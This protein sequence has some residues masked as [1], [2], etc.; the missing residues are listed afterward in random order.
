MC[1]TLRPVTGWELAHCGA[2]PWENA[3]GR[4]QHPWG[5]GQGCS[6]PKFPASSTVSGTQYMM[7]TCCSGSPDV[8]ILKVSQVPRTSLYLSDEVS[9][10]FPPSVKPHQLNKTIV[11]EDLSTLQSTQLWPMTWI[12]TQKTSQRGAQG[13]VK[14]RWLSFAPQGPGALRAP[15]ADH[16]RTYKKLNGKL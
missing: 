6:S 9:P 16:R 7:S 1:P 8:I 11:R 2:L 13:P 12:Y 3:T 10:W 15:S 4:R 14:L 5:Q